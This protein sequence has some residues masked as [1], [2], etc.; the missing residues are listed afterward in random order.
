M[1]ELEQLRLVHPGWRDVV[2]V[3]VVAY[4]LYR[5]LLLFHGTRTLQIV[6]G[7]LILLVVYAASWLLKLA[8]MKVIPIGR[9]IT[10]NEL[11]LPV[12]VDASAA[13]PR[14]ATINASERP[15]MVW[16]ARLMMIGPASVSRVRSVAG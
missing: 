10:V 12:A 4:T 11:R 2:E 15:T 9:I 7:L 16:L 13:A 5:V 8:M 14:C 6:T 1:T 3:V